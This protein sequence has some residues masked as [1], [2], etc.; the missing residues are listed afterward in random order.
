MG[1]VLTRLHERTS[2]Q[3]FATDFFLFSS[4]NQ[5]FLLTANDFTSEPCVWIS[6][7]SATLP[8]ATACFN[9]ANR[10]SC[11]VF[12]AFCPP[13]FQLLEEAHGLR[14]HPDTV[15]DLFRLCLRWVEHISLHSSNYVHLYQRLRYEHAC[16]CFWVPE[17]VNLTRSTWVI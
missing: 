4:S 17:R 5:A 8:K 2:W 13:T 14:N 6:L 3:V 1:W 10:T 15:D 12:Q 11:S 16:H 9:Q 7:T